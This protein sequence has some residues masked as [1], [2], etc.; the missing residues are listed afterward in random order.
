MKENASTETAFLDEL[1]AIEGIARV[2]TQTI[3]VM[4]V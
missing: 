4:S 1:K 3:T 2:E